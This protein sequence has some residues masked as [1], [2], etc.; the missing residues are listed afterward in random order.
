MSSK[1]KDRLIAIS[2]IIIV[3]NTLLTF[4]CY[5]EAD[6]PTTT[7]S[8]GGHKVSNCSL[9]ENGKVECGSLGDSTGKEYK[10]QDY[11]SKPWDRGAWRY[12][13]EEVARQIAANAILAANNDYI[14]YCQPHRQT[15]WQEAQKVD[16]DISQI[17]TPCAADCSGSTSTVIAITGYQLDI[18]ELKTVEFGYYPG[19]ISGHG[20]TQVCSYC[21]EGAWVN[22]QP[23]DVLVSSGHVTIYVGDATD[24]S[25]GG[26]FNYDTDTVNLDSVQ[27]KLKFSGLPK[28][29]TY[30]GSQAFPDIFEFLKGLLDWL[31]GLLFLGLKIFAM[32][33]TEVC[34]NI[35]NNL[36][37]AVANTTI[38]IS[39]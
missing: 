3:V 34:E 13:D 7:T 1:I 8:T 36:M 21:G 15:F 9:A 29:I 23:G 35:V 20:F 25:S 14:G 10:I 32:G 33:L 39:N 38:S 4:T 27:K 12:K 5:V 11:Y 19:S 18:D 22:L 37:H 16:Y 30:A 24:T 17:T 2:V 28:T 26:I 31:V 6:T